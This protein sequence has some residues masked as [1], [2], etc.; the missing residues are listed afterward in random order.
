[1]Q[2]GMMRGPLLHEENVTRPVP[3]NLKAGDEV[4]FA[5]EYARRI[6]ATELLVVQEAEVLPNGFVLV[7]GRLLPESFLGVPRGLRALKA[8]LRINQYHL[9]ARRL[10]AEQALFIT[11]EFSNGF[12][13]WVGDVLPKLE[14][15]GPSE[16]AGKSIIIPA[17]ADFE[18]ARQSIE[19]Y[20]FRD[21]R[22]LGW[23]E[24]IW[25]RE[26]GI[27]LPVAPTGNYR[28]A[29]MKRLRDRM[30]RHFGPGQP[31][32]R[33]FISR[34]ASAGRRIINESEVL[35][36]LQGFGFE[37]ILTEQLS[38]SEQVRL[39]GSASILIGNHG[40]GLTH[41]CWMLPGTDLFELRRQGDS[42]NN[43]YYSLA[44][45]LGIRYHYLTCKAFDERKA[46]HTADILVDVPQLKAELSALFHR[47]ETQ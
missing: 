11:D 41:A 30:R 22:F 17:M 16:T 5:H 4:L 21:I 25:C 15:L 12:F 26:L 27:V 34:A 31:E 42:A 6:P 14:A 33:L 40:A 9:L 39:V 7:N 29:I 37:R 45:A 18:Y 3:C 19:P 24:R 32:R 38:F 46:T 8:A 36:V 13:H 1:M 43:C 2:A 20:G 10:S 44:T 47:T 28:P 23:S 35:P